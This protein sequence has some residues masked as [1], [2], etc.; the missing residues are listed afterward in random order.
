MINIIYY[1]DILP[2][3]TRKVGRDLVVAYVL[4]LCVGIGNVAISCYVII[5]LFKEKYERI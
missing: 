3:R 1:V 4:T 5:L 2:Y